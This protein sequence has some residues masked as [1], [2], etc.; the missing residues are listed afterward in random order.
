MTFRNRSPLG[1]YG[2]V[3]EVMA[4]LKDSGIDKLGILAPE[5]SPAPG[6]R[7]TRPAFW[8][9][10]RL[11]F[12]ALEFWLEGADRFHERLAYRRR[13]LRLLPARRSMF[14]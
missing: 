13:L 8:G 5:E 4:I 1:P 9:G 2:D 3:V 7:L 12:D 6:R 11:W 14:L 10:Y